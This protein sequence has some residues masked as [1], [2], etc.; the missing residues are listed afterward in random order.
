MG[1]TADIALNALRPDMGNY[2][3][4]KAIARI[5]AE[6]AVFAQAKCAQIPLNY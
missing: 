2:L 1:R 3:E 4:E 5:A 6:S